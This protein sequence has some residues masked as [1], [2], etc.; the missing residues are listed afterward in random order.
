M[1]Y[2][3]L[4]E[5]PTAARGPGAD[6]R[7]Q[8]RRLLLRNGTVMSMDPAIGDFLTADVL[9][10]GDEIRAVAPHI[11]SD[12]P[13]LDCTGKLVIPGFVNSHIHM[14]QTALRGYW[15][16]GL[17]EHYFTQSRH[18]ERAIFHLYTPEDVYWGQYAGALEHINAGITTVVDTSQCTETPDHTDAAI[19]G[20]RASHVRAVYA[21]SPKAEGS[22]PHPSYAHPADITRLRDTVFPSDDQ[23]VTLAM[24]SPVHETNWRLARDLDLTIFSHVNDAAAGRHVEQ[25][26]QLGLA[27]AQNTYIH[28][29]GLD[30]STWRVIAETGGKVSLSN[31]VEQT[32]CTGMPGIQAALDHG[33]QPG[34]STDAVTLGPTDFFSQMRA[35]FALQRSRIQ[36]RRIQGEN[37]EAKMISTRDVLRMATIEGARAAHLDKKVGSLTP[38]KQAD[39]VLLDAQLLNASPVN[40]A[41]GAIVTLMDTSNVETVIIAGKVVKE[42]G[43]LLGVDLPRVVSALKR[44]AEGLLARSGYPNVLFTSCRS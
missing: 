13:A 1:N 20:L 23:L 6:S 22:T 16:D 44:S 35:T 30:A 39:I 11:D 31:L 37:V 32:L 40:H 38:G 19:E 41:A 36:E 14:F 10:E 43:R 25:L 9:I 34:F 26:S 24:G 21:F 33:I 27:G 15:T 3:G 18:G 5:D 4:P 17:A 2:T 8:S 7:D 28:C 42:T 29:T 12:A